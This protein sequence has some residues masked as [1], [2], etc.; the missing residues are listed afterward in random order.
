MK[1]T[2]LVSLLVIAFV[3]VC[4]AAPVFPRTGT[5]HG[6]GARAFSLANN[7]TAVSNDLTAL[8]WNPAGLAFLPVREFQMSLDGHRTN[9]SSDLSG[10]RENDY[11]ERMK[12]NNIGLMA[13]IP[14]VQG[15]FTMAAAYHNPFAFDDISSYRG[16]V[17]RGNSEVVLD[18]KYSVFGG[19][20]MWSGGFGVQ[21]A[22][23]LGAGVSASIVSGHEEV[24][25]HL[26]TDHINEGIK[27]DTVQNIYT[28][29]FGYDMRVGLMYNYADLFR[30]GTRLV[31]P[32]TIR[33]KEKVVE[34]T[35]TY[36]NGTESQSR[37]TGNYEG[38]LYS[39][40]SGSVGAALTLPFM[41]LTAEGRY[42]FPY[43]YVFPNDDI[44]TSSQAR[45][46]NTGAGLGVEVPLFFIP[47]ILRGG[48]SYDKYDLYPYIAH[49]KNTSRNWSDQQLDKVKNNL[50]TISAGV[51]IVTQNT[52]FEIGYSFQ[53]WGV[54]T[55]SILGRD[56]LNQDF[57]EH[58]AIATFSVRY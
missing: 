2:V 25:F 12:L 26:V 49:Y 7:Y 48:Y 22:P 43:T 23:N 57:K 56:M 17:R 54:S 31:F 55:I 10:Y 15:G 35:K 52:A 32:Q 34:E 33:F 42:T 6:V 40:M 53:T 45:Y 51:G 1:R 58:R 46:F 28:D 18:Q 38:K 37:T 44:P 14:T 27:T 3:S 19:L 16:T 29:F 8:Y 39:P 4:V 21:V 20:N 5:A 50:Q 24:R 41:T 47:V 30:I 9:I 36:R 11:H 13:A